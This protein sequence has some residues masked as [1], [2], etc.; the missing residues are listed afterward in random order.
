MSGVRSGGGAAGVVVVGALAV[1]FG[2]LF[3]GHPGSSLSSGHDPGT[4]ALPKT[5]EHKRLVG[6]ADGVGGDGTGAEGLPGAGLPG[7]EGGVYGDAPGT[8]SIWVVLTAPDDRGQADAW[9]AAGG[10]GG[11]TS[12]VTHPALRIGGTT[13]CY[14]DARNART[15]CT[16]SDG[17]YFLL[18][19]GQAEPGTV[20]Q[21]LVRIHDGAEQ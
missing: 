13:T 5:V 18:V 1:L 19:A 21:V 15:T 2:L 4:L 6:A 17:I 16:W 10:P 3:L 11:A 12:S 7:L 14:R 8:P 20:Q 9:L